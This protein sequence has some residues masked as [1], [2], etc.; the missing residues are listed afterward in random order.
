MTDRR[1]SYE[2]MNFVGI[3]HIEDFS[4]NKEGEELNSRLIGHRLEANET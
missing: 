4:D 3:C 1:D 2:V